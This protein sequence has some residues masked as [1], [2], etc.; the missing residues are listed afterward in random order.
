[1]AIISEIQEKRFLTIL[2]NWSI[3]AIIFSSISTVEAGA[4][5]SMKSLIVDAGTSV[6]D[7][8]ELLP[9]RFSF[10]NNGTS[11]LQIQRII[12]ACGCTKITAYDSLVMPGKS[13]S[14]S[15]EMNLKDF[16]AGLHS[17]VITVFSN[18]D[19]DSILRIA[20]KATVRSIIEIAVPYVTINRADSAWKSFFV[21]SKKNDINIEGVSFKKDPY[22]NSKNPSAWQEDVPLI[23]KYRWVSVDSIRS[24]GYKV[25]QLTLFMPHITES[26]LGFFR[27]ETNHPEKPEIYLRGTMLL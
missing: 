22:G 8:N 4:K 11:P 7:V 10:K 26:L 25:F 3:S 21:F 15:V 9:A 16:S 2:R 14:I 19:N 1:M 27:I 6:E 5:I 23:V 17:K 13:G 24:D 20:V 18:A 12:P